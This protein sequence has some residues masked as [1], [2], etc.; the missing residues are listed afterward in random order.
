MKAKYLVH[1]CNQQK[2]FTYWLVMDCGEKIINVELTKEMYYTLED[3][4]KGH[5]MRE[6][7]L[8][9]GSVIHSIEI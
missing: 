7:T 5:T 3:E 1:R 2:Y 9:D 8:P 6:T 4:L